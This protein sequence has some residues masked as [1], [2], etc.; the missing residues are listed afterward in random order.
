MGSVAMVARP[1]GPGGRTRLC[2]QCGLYLVEEAG[3]RAALLLRGPDEQDWDDDT[4]LE[5]A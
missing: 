2:V 5:A 1:A 4:R 3:T